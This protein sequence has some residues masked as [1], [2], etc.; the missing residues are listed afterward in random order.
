MHACAELLLEM[1]EE[2]IEYDDSNMTSTDMEGSPTLKNLPSR[3]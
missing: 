2:S 3:E 1:Y